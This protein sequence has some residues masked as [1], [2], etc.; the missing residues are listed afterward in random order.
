MAEDRQF[1]APIGTLPAPA[2]WV[3]PSGLEFQPKIA[4]AH[5][6]GTGAAGAFLPCLRLKSDAGIVA[7]EAVAATQVAAGA[8]ADVSWFLGVAR[9]SSASAI[10]RTLNIVINGGGSTI[11]T[12]IVGDVELDFAATIL[13]WTLL[14]NAAGSIVVNVWK[15]AYAG[16]PPTVANK[17]TASAP[18]TISSANKAQSSTLTGWTTA[19]SP[20]DTLRFNVDSVATIQR[21][22]LALDLQT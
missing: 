21:V 10:I 20:G 6:D 17:I 2:H 7:A 11:T 19:I 1:V 5:F 8:S 18:P 9:T 13:R 22:T 15:A 4:F 14:A 12:G 3:L 16:F